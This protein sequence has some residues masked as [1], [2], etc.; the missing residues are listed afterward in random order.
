MKIEQIKEA[1]AKRQAFKSNNVEAL[2]IGKD[3]H[4]KSYDTIIFT[5]YQGLDLKVYS[6]TTSKIQKFLYS[7]WYD[8]DLSKV[9]RAKAD[10]I[11]L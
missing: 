9:K 2:Y 11:K 6:K 4:V 1:L 7:L 10:F 5:D 8:K 3:Y